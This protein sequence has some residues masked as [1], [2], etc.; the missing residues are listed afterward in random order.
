[1]WS[2]A[3]LPF[4]SML[5]GYDTIVCPIQSHFDTTH[6]LWNGNNS[7]PNYLPVYHKLSHQAN[8]HEDFLHHNQSVT[9]LKSNYCIWQNQTCNVEHWLCHW[10]LLFCL[11]SISPCSPC[12]PSP[13]I[14]TWIFNI[15][16]SQPIHRRADADAD[17]C[18]LIPANADAKSADA[19][20]RGRQNVRVRTSLIHTPSIAWCKACGGLPIHDNW[21]YFVICYRW[22]V[23]SGNLS[24]SAFFEGGGS[25]W[26]EI[27]CGRGRRL[28][29]TVGVRRLEWLWQGRAATVAD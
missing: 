9:K 16:G 1:M 14:C 28:P 8:L 23:I 24:N 10:N 15:R 18:R 25:L 21:T 17:A 6:N 7:R 11:S 19:D 2:C 27:S 20:R 22:E 3:R 5:I 13:L 26:V 4:P 12:G 29:T